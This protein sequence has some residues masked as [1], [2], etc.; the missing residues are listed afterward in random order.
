MFRLIE[1]RSTP[2][3]SLT[4]MLAAPPP[5]SLPNQSATPRA[6]PLR[7]AV[8]PLSGL[9]PLRPRPPRPIKSLTTLQLPP[10]A[11]ACT[12]RASPP[13]PPTPT[14][15]HTTL[16]KPPLPSSPPAS[17]CTP[18]CARRFQ[19]GPSSG[20][21]WSS[22]LGHDAAR[23]RRREVH[24]AGFASRLQVVTL[25]YMSTSHAKRCRMRSLQPSEGLSKGSRRAGPTLLRCDRD[26]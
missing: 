14:H 7:Q 12:R 19:S 8:P 26:R 20:T 9:R 24:P 25:N 10:R 6:P 11:A 3:Y 23:R 15:S 21:I 2:Q 5:L 18:P 4:T 16:P 22:S 1:G 13:P 17:S